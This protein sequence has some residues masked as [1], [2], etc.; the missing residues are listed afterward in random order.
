MDSGRIAYPRMWPNFVDD[1]AAG[2]TRVMAIATTV[3]F[4]SG[5]FSGNARSNAFHSRIQSTVHVPR[6]AAAFPIGNA[7]TPDNDAIDSKLLPG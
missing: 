1:V 4:W 6:Q 7:S 2:I 5:C 3:S